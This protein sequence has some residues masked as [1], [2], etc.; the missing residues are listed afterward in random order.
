[1]LGADLVTQADTLHVT[2]SDV[3]MYG[4]TKGLPTT[5]PVVVSSGA[6]GTDYTA[7]SS[8]PWLHAQNGSVGSPL[9]WSVDP[10]GLAPGTYAGTITIAGTSSAAI[11]DVSYE[12]TPP[13]SMTVSPGALSFSESA[14]TTKGAPTAATC[15]STLWGDELEGAVGGVTPARTAIASSLQ[16]VHITNSGP[17]GSVLHW[18]AFFG[19]VTSSWISQDLNPPGAKVAQEPTQPIVSTQG[20]QAA[21]TSGDLS[22]ASTANANTLGG[23]SDMNQGTY[24]GLVMISDLADPQRVVS[25]L[26][27]VGLGT[28]AH[29]PVVTTSPTTISASVPAGQNSTTGLVLRDAAKS[30]GYAYSVSSDVPWA[31]VDPNSDVGVVAPGGGSDTVALTFDASGMSPGTY[32]GTITVQSANAE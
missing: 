8:A 14:V 6:A 16:T 18:S 13:A 5:Q 4:Y 23:Y 22:L 28:G 24:R 31:I 1:N 7:T 15:H 26:A 19:S 2:P 25:V 17:A 9:T 3:T 20:A 30:C 29:T 32:R 27:T 12:V 21:G 10:T 11:L